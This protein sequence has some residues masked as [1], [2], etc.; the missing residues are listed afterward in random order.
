MDR[1]KE[2]QARHERFRRNVESERASR[3]E[4]DWESEFR[5]MRRRV[6]LAMSQRNMRGAVESVAFLS[7]LW[8]ATLL[9]VV[10]AEDAVLGNWDDDIT[11][12]IRRSNSFAEPEELIQ[13]VAELVFTT[14][15]RPVGDGLER[16]RDE[17]EGKIRDLSEL[18]R[19]RIG[20]TS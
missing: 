11:Y 5:E 3:I 7:L 4:D 1:K 20:L 8:K 17:L 14:K 18:L 15:S 6:A 12:W 16:V 13:K 10:E 19:K 2:W 9:Y